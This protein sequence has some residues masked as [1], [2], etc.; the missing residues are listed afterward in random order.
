MLRRIVRSLKG[1]GLV[2]TIRLALLQ[3]YFLWRN[4]NVTRARLA[5]QAEYDRTHKVDTGGIIYLGDLDIPSK[6]AVFGTR[7]GPTSYTTFREIMQYL[8]IDHTQFIFI[9]IGSGK[10]AVLFYAS[11]WPFAKI[12]GIE[13]SPQ[14][15]QIAQRNVV[16]YRSDSQ[17]C[18]AIEAI[19]ADASQYKLPN[20]PLVL[21]FSS[22]FGME[23]MGTVWQNIYR[24]VKENGH[25][26][27]LI[28]NNIGYNPDVDAFLS[29]AKELSLLT[30]RGTYRI[31]R[32]GDV[33]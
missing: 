30:D 33:Y 22:P 4:K 31:Y 28:Y 25:A 20:S 1:K 8:P 2:P 26:C 5:A 11:D 29:H 18:F 17:K 23:V 21:Y 15:H 14:L 16:D 27:F 6:N 13:F 3:P 32:V 9:D 12:I 7:Y 19:C 10:G 24:S